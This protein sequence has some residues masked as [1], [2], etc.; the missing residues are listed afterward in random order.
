MRPIP[1]KIIYKTE[2]GYAYIKSTLKLSAYTA[3]VT[4][5]S[6]GVSTSLDSEINIPQDYFPVITEYIQK[7]LLITKALPQDIANDGADI[8][9]K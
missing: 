5:I 9:S 6:G 2:G 8:S 4:L 7:Q 1:N 3:S